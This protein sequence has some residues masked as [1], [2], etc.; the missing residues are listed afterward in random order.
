MSWIRP[1]GF[2]G[3]IGLLVLILIYILKPNYQQKAISSTFVWKLSLKY[4]KKR[5]PISKLKNI[6]LFI[7]QVLALVSC[8]LILAQPVIKAQPEDIFNEKIV[9]LDSS[10]NM[11]AQ[12]D[13]ETRFERAVNEI[14]ALAGEAVDA[15][16]R[17]SVIIACAEP[18]FLAQRTEAGQMNELIAQLDGLIPSDGDIKCTFGTADIGKAMSLAETVLQENSASDVIFFTGTHYTDKGEVIVRDVSAEGEWNAAVLNVTADT[19]TDNYYTFTVDVACYGKDDKFLLHCDVY[20]ANE[21]SAGYSETVRME[22]EVRCFDDKTQ[23]VTFTCNNIPNSEGM[24]CPAVY[25]Y[26]N[27]RI[28]FTENDSFTDDNSFYLYGGKLPQIKIQ[29]ASSA[30]NVFVPGMAMALRTQYSGVYDIVY[31]EVRGSD[32][33]ATEGY[34]YYIFEHSTIPKILPNDGVVLLLDPQSVPENLGIKFDR[35][36]V[37]GQFSLEAVGTHKLTQYMPLKYA[38]IRQYAKVLLADGYDTVLTV[39]G[40][41]AL[42]VRNDPNEKIV[43]MPISINWSDIAA[44]GDF[45]VFLYNMFNYFFPRTFNSYAYEVGNVAQFNARGEEFKVNGPNNFSASFTEFPASLTLN[46]PGIYTVT[47]R[48]ISGEIIDERFSVKVSAQESMINR[49]EDR[50]INPYFETRPEPLDD[51]LLIWFAAALLALLFI[52]WQIHTYEG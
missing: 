39:N 8:A 26:D 4:R 18:Y 45:S 21:D 28:Y 5:L 25:S 42:L 46:D 33:P 36:F 13:G 12:T 23:T 37:S 19:D 16:E 31:D 1:L 52:E 34:D 14:K 32:T 3:L 9:V 41:P 10:A 47:Q 35:N 30:P 44:T 6:L 7:C 48:I 22:A 49:T 38:Q 24:T 20:G 29:Y 2:L 27:A 40:D 50:L 11:R 17:I 15:N 51:D 43:V